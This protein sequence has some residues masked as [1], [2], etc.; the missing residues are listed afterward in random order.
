L[1]GHVEEVNVDRGYESNN[2][3]RHRDTAMQ[4]KVLIFD[5][6]KSLFP[7]TLVFSRV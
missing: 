1:L 3:Y 6:E 4:R 7:V 2:I 5:I